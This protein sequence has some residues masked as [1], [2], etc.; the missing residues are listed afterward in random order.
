MR[1]SLVGVSATAVGVS[2]DPGRTPQAYAAPATKSLPN[3][4]LAVAK[5]SVS[6]RP[7]EGVLLTHARGGH[8]GAPGDRRLGLHGEGQRGEG[9]RRAGGGFAGRRP[10]RG[11]PGRRKGRGA[12]RTGTRTGGTGTIPPAPRA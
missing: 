7:V 8:R 3:L 10:G 2:A 11:R 1:C 4:D 9:R 5:Q 6:P 12:A